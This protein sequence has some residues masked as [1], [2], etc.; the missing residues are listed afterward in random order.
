MRQTCHLRALHS[1]FNAFGGAAARRAMN[2]NKLSQMRLRDRVFERVRAANS[3]GKAD[4]GARKPAEHMRLSVSERLPCTERHKGA[5]VCFRRWRR[6]PLVCPQM[7]IRR[8]TG[9]IWRMTWTVTGACEDN[10][11]ASAGCTD[12][13]G[14]ARILGGQYQVCVAVR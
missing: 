12:G 9:S 8:L 4:S 11:G 13:T 7:T 2:K 3:R 14:A 6:M 5:C 1:N 10:P